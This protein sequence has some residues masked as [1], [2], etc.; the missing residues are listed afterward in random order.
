MIRSALIGTGALFA[1]LSL[2]A[3]GGSNETPAPVATSTQPAATS[4]PSAAVSPAA[5]TVPSLPGP[6]L[7]ETLRG[8]GH[9]V[10]FRHAL[11]DMSQSDREP[12]TARD[13]SNQRNLSA[14]G[15]E[16]S[17]MLGAEIRRL[18]IPYGV[19][20]TS[21][22]CRTRETAGLAFGTYDID[23]AL[24]QQLVRDAATT[25][26]V[27][28]RLLSAVPPAGLN[29]M[30]VTHSTNLTVLGL[31]IIDEGDAI[32]LMPDGSGWTAVALVKAADWSAIP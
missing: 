31:P 12:F 14:A 23:L 6:R 30:M 20:V 25:A 15:R 19:A 13:C 5:I 21:P 16:Q 24:E 3:C 17:R 1:A 9:I 26:Q 4:T 10:I 11:T 22:Y 8:G 7:V 2:I 32:V 18:G 28:S 27:M 29:T